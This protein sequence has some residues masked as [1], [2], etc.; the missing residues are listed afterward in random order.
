MAS[1][2]LC[3]EHFGLKPSPPLIIL[4]FGYSMVWC[5]SFG[6]R[7]LRFALGL[8]ALVAASS[9]YAGPYGRFLL[10]ERNFFGVSRVAND[11]NGKLRYLFHGAIVHGIQSLDPA[12]SREPEAYYTKSGPAG[13]ILQAMEARSPLGNSADLPKP[14][15]AVVGLG[16]GAMACYVQPGESLTF[17]E[18]D[19]NVRG[20]ASNPQYFTFLSQCAPTAPIVLGDARLKLRDAADSSYDLIVLDAFSGDT[21][22]M[23]LVTREALALYL[24]KLAPSGMLAFHISNNHLKLAPVFAALASDAGL[25]SLIDDD[26]VLTH[27]QF[28]EG[29]YP[30][31]WV[32]MAR[33]RADLGQLAT[34]RRWATLLAPAGTQV[35]TDD[36]SN[37]IR[38]IKWN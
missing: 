27:A 17:Y 4:L 15:W 11:Q 24:R 37:L 29:K 16:A 19:P 22:P 21:I 8:A 5:L 1:L 33:T 28:D 7:P 9:L 32:V 14:R 35:W 13:S 3:F 6:K 30:S 25:V 34:D 38:I 31:Q 26:T 36:Y 23:H 12:K 10:K 20:I 2:I 18:I